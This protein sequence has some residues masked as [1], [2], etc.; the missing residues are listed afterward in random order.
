MTTTEKRTGSGVGRQGAGD[1]YDPSEIEPKWQA[2]W[3]EEGIYRARDHEP[4][5]PNWFALTMFPYPSG[6]LHIGHWYA[7]GPG[8]AHARFKRMQGYNVMHPQ[9][10][11]AFGLP[12]ENA[13]IQRNIH[14]REWT[15]SNI[16]NMR[17]QFRRMG[18]SYDWSREVVTCDP[19]YYRWNQWLFLQMYR[20]GLA[21]QAHGQV[22]WCPHCQTTLANEQ[23]KEGKCERCETTVTRRMMEQ[24][25]FR[26]TKYADELLDMDGI[27]WPNKIKVMQTNWIGRSEGVDFNFDISEHGLDEK[28]ITTFT[29]RIDTVYGVTFLVL[30]PE[31]RLVRD[32]TQPEHQQQVNE[33]VE[34]ARQQTEIERMST[35]REKTGVFTG[36]YAV[37]PLNG[38]RVPVYVGDYVLLGYG[39]GA[40]MGVPAHDERDF[41]FA[42]KYGLPI[43]VVVAPD[44][45][46]GEELEDAYLGQ[47]TQVNSEEFD[48]LPS[49]EGIERIA[50]K[51]EANGLGQRR[52]TYRMRDWLISRQRY[53]GTPIPIV[54]CDSCGAMPVPEE[55]LPV[56]LPDDAQF[57]PTGRSPLLDHQDFLNTECPQ[58]GGPATRETDTMDAFMD[59]SWYH[60]RYTSPHVADRPFDPDSVKAWV[61]VHQYMGGAEHAVMHL[62]YARFFNKAL[63]D[64]G[65]VDYDEPYAR[66]FSQGVLLKDHAKISK[67]SNPLPPDPL[68]DRHGADAV[69]CYLMFLGPWDQ[70]GDWSDEAFA[71]VTRW[72]NRVWDQCVRDA[73]SLPQEASDV[74][75]ERDLVR[76]AHQTTKRVLEDL[77]RFK[78]NTAVAALM[79]YST[80]LNR[81]WETGSV[82]RGGWEDAVRR[83]LLLLAPLAPHITEELWERSGNEFSIHL[84]SLP[85]WDEGLAAEDTVNVAVQVNGKLRDTVQLPAGA[86]EDEAIEAA[87]GSQKVQ[88]RV[89]GMQVVKHIYVPDKLVNLVVK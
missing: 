41:V 48:G 45:W 26:I 30:A 16:E 5:K 73:S 78:F 24:W 28:A 18:N 38:E 74:A 49:E 29:T 53:W 35:E 66:L 54:Y 10:F 84:Q 44:G 32:L 67:R 64:L 27:D 86:S 21:Y 17:R 52:V 19:D 3:E 57:T 34:Q 11:D 6:D 36:A 72:L 77:E 69:R 9:G 23:V 82:S 40:V 15:Y 79:D 87:L 88:A 1:S 83:M 60:L 62:L 89:E 47:G 51:I 46:S 8:D 70:G 63:R 20:A 25:Y 80:R 76:A 39:T 68:V 42:K 55:D 31:H 56:T 12:A 22:N 33:Y 59:S 58:C 75:A 71:G 7:F 61:P 85:D 81:L 65:M 14:P 43:R 4:G 2:R 50:D 13:A 37:N